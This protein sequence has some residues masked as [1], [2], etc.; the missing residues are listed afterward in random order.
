MIETTRTLTQ[1]D[2][3]AF[4]QISGDDNPIHVDPDFAARTFFKRT[5]AHGA[6]LTALLRALAAPMIGARTVAS[7]A[8][9]FPAPTFADEPLILKAQPLAPDR[10]GCDITRAHDGVVT[11][12]VEFVLQ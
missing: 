12:T 11:C 3:T 1:D 10:I 4:A 5:V 2:F 9:M 8:A 7:Q 6:M